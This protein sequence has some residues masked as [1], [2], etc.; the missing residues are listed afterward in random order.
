MLN[1]VIETCILALAVIVILLICKSLRLG[2]SDGKNK[3]AQDNGVAIAKYTGKPSQQDEKLDQIVIQMEALPAEAI[4]EDKLVEITDNK[5]LAQ[6]SSLVPGLLQAGNAASNARRAVGLGKEVLYRAIL[7]SDAELAKSRT[8]ENAFR[9]IFHGKNGIRGQAN[10]EKVDLQNGT[11]VAAN[12]AAAAM[13]V[14]SMVVGQYYMTQINKELESI[15][16]EIESI[17]AFQKVEFQA[18]VI[19][20]VANVK[21]LAD[22][23]AEI[24]ENSELRKEK[25]AQLDIM[26]MECTKLLGQANLALQ[27]VAQETDCDY[28]SYEKKLKDAQSWYMY[29]KA[30]F[31]VLDRI[32]DLRYTLHLGTVSREQCNSL[33]KTYSQ[34]VKEARAQLASW[35]QDTANRLGIDADIKKRRREG[36]DRILYSIPGLFNDKFNYKEIDATTA[37]MIS[38]Q[39][40]ARSLDCSS[41]NSNLFAEEVQLISKGGKIYYLPMQGKKEVGM[42]R[43]SAMA[44]IG[45]LFKRSKK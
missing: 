43:L 29:Q 15:S 4:D 18:S 40:S 2:V 39:S 27:G 20:L 44:G 31:E 16:N 25:I 35:H 3:S 24:M 22:F 9:G 26:Q 5:V 1:V 10:F 7:P 42:C 41:D 17:S 28:T 13:Q 21:A 11:A 33:L 8:M 6:V 23:Q 36:L 14:A 37:R 30:L 12:T 19:S 38:D 45:S 34:Q 32:S